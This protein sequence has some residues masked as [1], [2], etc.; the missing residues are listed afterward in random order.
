MVP[1]FRI[2]V[3]PALP[4]PVKAVL[5]FVENGADIAA[6]TVAA[7]LVMRAPPAEVLVKVV[8]PPTAVP[9]RPAPEFKMETSPVIAGPPPLVA[10]NTR[11]KGDFPAGAASV[12]NVWELFELLTTPAPPAIWR[13]VGMIS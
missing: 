9:E 7:L 8:L 5:P 2:V 10:R 1:K 12:K 11:E 3:L 4:V 13:F 6:A